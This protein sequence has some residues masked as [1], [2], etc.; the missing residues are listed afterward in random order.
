M[1]DKSEFVDM[2]SEAT[3]QIAPPR[4]AARRRRPTRPRKPRGSAIGRRTAGQQWRMETLTPWKI[5]PWK[6]KNW[7]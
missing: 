5:K 6:F 4:H 3:R 2:I 1:A 7:D